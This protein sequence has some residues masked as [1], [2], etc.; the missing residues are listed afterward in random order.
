MIIINNKVILMTI[1]K[2]TF[3]IAY[4]MIGSFS[5]SYRNIVRE[6]LSYKD[7][8][9][10]ILIEPLFEDYSQYGAAESKSRE[11]EMN[12]LHCTAHTKGDVKT[13]L[14][15]RKMQLSSSQ[16]LALI[17]KKM[18]GNVLCY[19]CLNNRLLRYLTVLATIELLANNPTFRHTL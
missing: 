1:V 14:E 17:M 9:F 7:R 2:Q 8:D 16:L 15:H 13:F 18:P 19:A 11:V 4:I 6:F 3:I 10:F 12:S 5:T